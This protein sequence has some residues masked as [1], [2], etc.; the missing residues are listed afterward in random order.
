LRKAKNEDG[1]SQALQR[2]RRLIEKAEAEAEASAKGG[3][4]GKLFGR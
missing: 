1:D 2:E 3:L 4:A